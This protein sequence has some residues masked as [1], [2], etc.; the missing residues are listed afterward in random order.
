MA[1]KDFS[2]Q[3]CAV[4]YRLCLIEFEIFIYL[5][6][7]DMKQPR[8]MKIAELQYQYNDE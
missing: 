2:R 6:C 3:I 1:L 4:N 7:F 5:L 8:K